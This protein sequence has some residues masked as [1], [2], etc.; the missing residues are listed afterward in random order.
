MKKE[1]IQKNIEARRQEIY[2]YQINIDV[3]TE[4]LDKLTMEWRDDLKVYIGL[5]TSDI[6]CKVSQEDLQLVSDLNFKEKIQKNLLAE[7]L[8]QSKA[9]H[10]LDALL[11]L[12]KTCTQTQT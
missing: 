10:V 1:D 4:I 11:R 7:K 9:Q 8:E 3:Y 6:V 12:E 5:E 2:S